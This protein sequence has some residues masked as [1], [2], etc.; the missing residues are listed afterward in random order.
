[1][2]EFRLIIPLYY[3]K[4]QVSG[5]G[6]MMIMGFSKLSNCCMKCKYRPRHLAV[7]Y[8][9]ICTTIKLQGGIYWSVA[10]RHYT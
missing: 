6:Y 7:P 1:M 2:F 10:E 4:Y 8:N 3:T 5:S 9:V